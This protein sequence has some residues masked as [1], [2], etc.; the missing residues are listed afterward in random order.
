M[1]IGDWMLRNV[2]E[3]NNYDWLVK[4]ADEVKANLVT[5]HVEV[6]PAMNEVLFPFILPKNIAP[7]PK[8]SKDELEQRSRS[9]FAS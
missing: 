4:L 7:T 8:V 6:T 9:R 3:T 2:Y 1:F 5:R